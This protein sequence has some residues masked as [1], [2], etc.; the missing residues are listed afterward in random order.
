MIEALI[1]RLVREAP[2]VDPGTLA[3]LRAALETHATPLARSIWR[4]L[5][6]VDEQLVDPGVALPAI[7]EACAT[8]VAEPADALAIDAARYR[9]DTLQPVPGERP[10]VT[11]DVPVSALSRGPPPRT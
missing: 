11:P 9:I 5:E 6:L 2:A 8:L 4:A 3:E 10:L 1:T 7:A